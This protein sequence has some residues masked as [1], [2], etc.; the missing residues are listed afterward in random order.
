LCFPGIAR[1]RWE[2]VPAER[3][4][5]TA[6][7]YAIAGRDVVMRR[8][9]THVVKMRRGPRYGTAGLTVVVQRRSMRG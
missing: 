7:I 1:E 3:G 9:Y 5:A 8:T 4:F 6:R 2:K